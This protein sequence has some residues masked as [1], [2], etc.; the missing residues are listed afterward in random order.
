M[1]STICLRRKSLIYVTPVGY[2]PPTVSWTH[3]ITLLL[4]T[5]CSLFPPFTPPPQSPGSVPSRHALLRGPLGGCSLWEQGTLREEPDWFPF[6]RRFGSQRQ[7]PR[8]QRGP[9]RGQSQT[10]QQALWAS[11]LAAGGGHGS[12]GGCG[13]CKWPRAQKIYDF[14]IFHWFEWVQNMSSGPQ[15]KKN[16]ICSKLYWVLQAKIQT[17]Q[18]KV[19]YFIILNF[20]NMYL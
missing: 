19:S 18:Q 12:P 8:S 11:G 9:S 6:R 7:P 15:G 14:I 1:N 17:N 13:R 4:P 16:L 5:S 10:R 20:S 3:Q 2:P